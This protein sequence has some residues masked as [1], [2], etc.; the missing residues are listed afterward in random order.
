MIAFE[1]ALEQVLEHPLDL[2][3][4][5]VALLKSAG[6]ILAEDIEADR[7]FPPFDRSTKDGIAIAFSAIES[8]SDSF[9]IEGVLSAGMPQGTLSSP[10]HCLEI[11]TGAVLPHNADTIVMYEHT[12]IKDGR[13]K[14]LKKPVRGQNI[15]GRG[16][17]ITA[18]AIL[19]KKGTPITPAVI[20]VLAS[21]G[22]T[23]VLVKKLPKVCVVS[24]GNELVEVEETPLPHQ[25]RKSNVL[26]L[27][28]ELT[29]KSIDHT[30]LH[31]PD[32]RDLIAGALE[33]ALST[34]DVLMLS[35][36]VSKGKFDYVPEVLDALGI[37]KIFHR[38]AQ[39]PGKPFWFG[40]QKERNKVVF[41]F[42]GNPVSTFANYHVYFLAWLDRLLGQNTGKSTVIVDEPVPAHT[43]LTLFLQ[44]ETFWREGQLHGKLVQGNGSGD[45]VNLA[46][47]N[48]FIQVAPGEHTFQ[49]G[50]V[51]PFIPV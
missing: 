17:D 30:L 22:K 28:A 6:R 10:D 37:E 40:V 46:Q 2:G 45:L 44:V 26:S 49:K 39:R 16:S 23:G 27:S 19:L 21:V 11:M 36:G 42:P 8:G 9:E 38:V 41:S 31:L 32:D 5:K 12:E 15:H 47:A 7:D 25:I 50:S 24:T 1:N 3:T 51:F 33:K 29:K 18:G 48:G 34:H 13:A 20:G 4:E 14:I 35:G 43:A